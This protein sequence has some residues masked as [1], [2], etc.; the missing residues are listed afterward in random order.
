M[1]HGESNKLH[2]LHGAPVSLITIG[3][4]RF[5]FFPSQNAKHPKMQFQEEKAGEAF[6]PLLTRAGHLSD[7]D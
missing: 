1:D 6:C 7:C 4:H 2:H 5:N 3:T